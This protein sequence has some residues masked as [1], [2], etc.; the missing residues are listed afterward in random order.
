[1]GGRCFKMLAAGLFALAAWTALSGSAD[2]A[3]SPTPE[4]TSLAAEA[5]PGNVPRIAGRWNWVDGHMLV[6]YADGTLE[7]FKGLAKVND[8]RWESL[9]DDRYR[10]THRNGGWVD[11]MTLSADGNVLD[12]V[13][14]HGSQ[15][16]GTRMGAQNTNPT[17]AGASSGLPGHW[18][19]VGDQTLEI[20]ANGTFEVF[21]GLVKINE[22]QWVS[23]GGAQFRLTHYKG[24]WVDTVNLS[25]DANVIDGFNNQGNPVRG[26]R[27]GARVTNPTLPG[28]SEGLPGHWNWVGDQTLEISANGTFE[29]FRGLVKINEGKWVSLGGAQFRLTHYRGGWVDTVNLSADANV[30]DGVNNQGN[31]VRGTRQ[32]ARVTNPTLPGAAPGLPGRWE[33]VAGQTLEI[34]ANGTFEVFQGLAKINEGRWVSL[35]GAEFR[36]THSNGGWID[37][38][39]LSAD[40]KTLTGTNNRGNPVQGTRR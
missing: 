35:G 38:V 33:W 10:F 26:T 25:A 3:P 34:S 19:W 6:L 13:N 29:V 18:D 28:A 27:Q 36:F 14:N 37:T 23:L 1:M 39:T 17:V 9:G 31:A 20:S 40:G 12:G 32:G 5:S 15:L 16:R 21:K 2:A 24:G 11:T 8:G 30:I 7:A 22:G 4:M